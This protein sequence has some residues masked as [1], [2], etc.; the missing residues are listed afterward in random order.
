MFRRMRESFQRFMYGR[1]GTD[2]LNIVLLAAAVLLSLVNSILAAI[3]VNTTVY[4]T[5]I[6]P[7]LWTIMVALLVYCTF[8]TL[9]KNIYQRQRENKAVLQFWRALTD[10]NNRYFKCPKCKQIVRV[11]RGRGKISIRCP[12]CNE[13]FIKKT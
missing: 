7:I 11:P 8:R 4:S 9:S 10:R 13:R 12:K 1:Y 3:F 5:I 2:Q 6:Y